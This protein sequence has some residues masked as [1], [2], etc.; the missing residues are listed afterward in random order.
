[1]SHPWHDVEH[2]PKTPDLIPAVIEVPKGSLRTPRK[3]SYFPPQETGF[4][5][6][7][8]RQHSPPK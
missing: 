7:Q 5:N 1:M 6:K 4:N 3:G 2:D 8:F